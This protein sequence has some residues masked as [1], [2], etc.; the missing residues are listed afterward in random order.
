MRSVGR[1]ESSTTIAWRSCCFGP[2]VLEGRSIAFL[3]IDTVSETC[4]CAVS[5]ILVPPASPGDASFL[6]Q[7]RKQ[8]KKN[9][10][11]VVEPDRAQCYLPHRSMYIVAMFDPLITL[12]ASFVS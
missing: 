2:I 11:G 7:A 8:K 12:H 4:P 5:K 6:V 3:Q 9:P 1:I 10:T